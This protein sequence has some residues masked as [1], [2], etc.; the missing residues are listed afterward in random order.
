VAILA[1]MVLGAMAGG[2]GAAKH[3]KKAKPKAAP[4]FCTNP[5]DNYRAPLEKLQKMPAVPE[6]GALPF[7]TGLTLGITGPQ[8]VLVGG[9][10]VGFRLTDTA[11]EGTV[12]SRLDWTVLERL[13]RLTQNG[14]NPHPEGLKRINLGQLPAGKYRGL[15][16]ALPSKPA[17]YSL[18]VTIQNRRGRLLGR[19]GEYL[20]VVNRTVDVGISLAAYDGIAPGSY[21]ES[22]F[23]NH[24]SASVT[25]GWTN[26]ERF[27]GSTWRPVFTGP[28]YAP[29]QTPIQRTL[30]PGE[31]EKIGTLVPSNA[32]P[33]L[34][35]LTAAGLTE[36]GEPIALT[37]EFGVG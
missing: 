28:R 16:F 8:G 35:R 7:A 9:S 34:Y 36:L 33:G 1:L 17:I 37:A 25:P 19:Y 30:G 26:L 13:T 12:A 21:L 4:A 27:D 6:G 20:R 11:P 18:E 23:E 10:S 14:Q 31:S 3:K 24:G 22:C 29:E 32:L 2:A 15:T 5:A